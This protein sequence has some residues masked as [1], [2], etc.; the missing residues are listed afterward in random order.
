MQDSLIGGLVGP[1]LFNG[2]LEAPGLT[3]L[4]FF[5]WGY[6]KN[7]VYS[8]LIKYLQHLKHR[9]TD[10]VA[11]IMLEMIQR[12][13]AK[14]DYRLDVCRATYGAHTETL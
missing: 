6:V 8:E 12:C 1:V 4:D 14:I 7:I 3:P 13:W 9:I 11:T 10:A 2:L 5:L